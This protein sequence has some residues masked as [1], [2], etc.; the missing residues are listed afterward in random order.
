MPGMTERFE[1][2]V[3]KK[4]LCNSYTELNDPIKQRALFNDQANCKAQVRP[5]GTHVSLKDK[6]IA[7]HDILSHLTRQL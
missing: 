1:L 2:F 7:A 6:R 3:N 5:W 4:E